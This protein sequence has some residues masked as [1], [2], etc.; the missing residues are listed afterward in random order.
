MED[1][2]AQKLAARMGRGIS[3]FEELRKDEVIKDALGVIADEFI[4]LKTKEWQTYDG[5][6]TPWEIENYLTFF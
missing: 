4:E 2:E 5:Q 3:R 6:V 1:R